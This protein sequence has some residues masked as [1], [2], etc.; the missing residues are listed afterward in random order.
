MEAKKR[1]FYMDIIQLHRKGY[2]PSRTFTMSDPIEDLQMEAKRL[3][4]LELVKIMECCLKLLSNDDIDYSIDKNWKQFS[5][6]KLVDELKHL[7]TQ[8]ATR[9]AAI[10]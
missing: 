3:K 1:V 5:Y 2:T 4:T 9:A 6:D 7:N 10:A 8:M